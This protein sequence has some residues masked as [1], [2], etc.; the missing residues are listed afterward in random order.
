MKNNKKSVES[1]K[2]NDNDLVNESETK[3]ATNNKQLIDVAFKNSTRKYTFLADKSIV[4]KDIVLCSTSRGIEIGIVV[5]S[6]LDLEI[7]N[8]G[9]VTFPIKKANFVCKSAYDLSSSR[10]MAIKAIVNSFNVTFS[11]LT[12]KYEELKKAN[13][14]GLPF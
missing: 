6:D 14:D 13:F 8:N 5:N 12:N 1:I 11:E 9:E 2:L 3:K 4:D 10:N 7:L